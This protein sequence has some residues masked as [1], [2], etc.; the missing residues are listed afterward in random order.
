[1]RGV[2]HKSGHCRTNSSTGARGQKGNKTRALKFEGRSI[3]WTHDLVYEN[4]AWTS[5]LE[6]ETNN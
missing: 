2:A 6:Q 1:M 4:M 5:G 3:I